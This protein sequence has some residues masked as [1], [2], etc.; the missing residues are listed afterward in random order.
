MPITNSDQKYLTITHT[1]INGTRWACKFLAYLMAGH[2]NW[3]LAKDSHRE[4][5]VK[6]QKEKLLKQ[7]EE[8][9]RMDMIKNI[10]HFLALFWTL[11]QIFFISPSFLSEWILIL[12]VMPMVKIK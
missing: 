1:Y 3:Q 5:L 6:K 11:S 9:A 8:D 10:S 4:F 2:H 12:T 7:I